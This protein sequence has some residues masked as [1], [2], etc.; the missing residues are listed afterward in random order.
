MASAQ[1]GATLL[2]EFDAISTV[3]P[4]SKFSPHYFAG[5]EQLLDQNVRYLLLTPDNATDED[6]REH[7]RTKV[8]AS[9]STIGLNTRCR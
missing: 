9:D 3:N 4:Q 6:V 7:A 5:D 1:M 2:G 8:G